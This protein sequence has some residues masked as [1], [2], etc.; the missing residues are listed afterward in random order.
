VCMCVSIMDGRRSWPSGTAR[1]DNYSCRDSMF[2]IAS[3]QTALHSAYPERAVP[4]ES[5]FDRQ[6][7]KFASPIM[8]RL[9]ERTATRTDVVGPVAEEGRTLSGLRDDQL[10]KEVVQLRERLRLEG[11]SNELVFRSFALVREVAHRTI[12]QR[13]YDVQVLG[14]WVLLNGCV[15]EMATG[16]GKTLT[17]TLAAATAALAGVPVHLITVNDYLTARD[18]EE[19]GPIYQML[20]LTVGVITHEQ[21]PVARRAA[22][23]CDVTYC[24]NKELVFDYLRDRLAVVEDL[25]VVEGGEYLAQ[26]CFVRDVE[27]AV[28]QHQVADWVHGQNVGE[29]DGCGER[30]CRNGDGAVEHHG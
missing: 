4:R 10:R 3:Q 13:H 12:G 5:W 7:V 26:R 19:M 16:E 20:G 29:D 2:D 18:A 14:G 24:T 15:A 6:G 17:A 9:R 22:Y 23:A 27:E 11:F 28:L 25:D 30:G 21:S 8:R 1:D